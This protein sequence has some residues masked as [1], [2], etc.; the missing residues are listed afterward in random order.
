MEIPDANARLAERPAVESPPSSGLGSSTVSTAAAAVKKVLLRN[1]QCPG[2]VLML[3]AAVRDLYRA[4]GG[5]IE[6]MVETSCSQLWDFNPYVTAFDREGGDVQTIDCE[7]PLIQYSNQTPYH[8]IH[9]F[10]Q[11]LETELGLRIPVTQFQGDIHLAECERQWMSQVRELGVED[12]FWIV[13]AGG[14]Y[15]FTTKWWNPVKYQEVVDYFAGRITFVQCGEPNHW[16]PPLKN[17]INLIGKTDLRQFIR[18]V[19]H[20]SGVLCPITFAMHAAAAVPVPAGRAPNRACVVI[21]GGREPVHWEAY[22]YHRFLSNIGSLSC[23]AHGACWKSRCQPV[24]DGDLKDHHDRCQQPVAVS[25]D[26]SI[27]R[28]MEM[29]RVSDVIRAIESYYEGGVLRYNGS[30]GA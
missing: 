2:D 16:H 22:P 17:V 8:F 4:T 18:L 24:G 14:K 9:G 30:A 28:C 25:P 23:S 7:Y 5:M 3:T 26:L 12:D 6:I 21:A 19:H 27:A 29:I 1:F 13:M 15:D 20:S 11:H 10:V